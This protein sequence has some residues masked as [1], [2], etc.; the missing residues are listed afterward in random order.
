MKTDYLR[1]VITVYFRI[2]NTVVD[3]LIISDSSNAVASI[4]IDPSS[5]DFSP[6]VYFHQLINRINVRAATCSTA[7]ICCHLQSSAVICR[8]TVI[9]HLEAS[10]VTPRIIRCFRRRLSFIVLQLISSTS[11]TKVMRCPTISQIIKK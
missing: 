2:Y 1:S 3:A 11:P 6:S 10:R 5:I 7:V 8:D 9:A 4:I